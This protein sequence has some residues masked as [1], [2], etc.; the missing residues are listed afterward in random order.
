MICPLNHLMSTLLLWVNLTRWHFFLLSLPYPIHLCFSLQHSPHFVT[1][2]KTVEQFYIV[3]SFS[4]NDCPSFNCLPSST[5]WVPCVCETVLFRIKCRQ[6]DVSL[7]NVVCVWCEYPGVWYWWG[8]GREDYGTWRGI[9][10]APC[11]VQLSHGTM[12]LPESGKDKMYH[13]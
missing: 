3:D 4:S 9:Q 10:L 1:L 8:M 7:L 11:C 12:L 5:N 13:R 2:L 6:G